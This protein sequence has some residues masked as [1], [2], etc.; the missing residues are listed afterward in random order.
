MRSW[1]GTILGRCAS[2]ANSRKLVFINRRIVPI[3]SAEARAFEAAVIRTVPILVPLLG[4]RLR[5]TCKVFYDSERPDLDASVIMDALQ[6][7][8]YANDRQIRE[9]HLFHDVDRVNP[10]AVVKVE[11]IG[12]L[13]L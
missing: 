9:I 2:K 11:E 4:G 1:Q 12:A 10:R 5:F 13:A 8:I 3:K 6:K 7:R